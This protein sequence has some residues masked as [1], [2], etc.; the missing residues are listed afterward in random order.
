MSP[1]VGSG[2]R[3]IPQHSC[4]ET[5]GKNTHTFRKHSYNNLLYKISSIISISMIY[6]NDITFG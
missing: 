1:H 5:G 4:E 3:A 2:Q 6:D